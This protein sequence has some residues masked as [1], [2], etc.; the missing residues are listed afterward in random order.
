ML[1]ILLIILAGII[2]VPLEFKLLFTVER[3]D[4]GRIKSIKPKPY[5]KHKHN[6]HGN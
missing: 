6:K 4:F 3:D 1:L 2:I 5:N